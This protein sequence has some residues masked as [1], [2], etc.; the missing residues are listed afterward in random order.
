MLLKYA[1]KSD[2]ITK[3][4]N[5]WSNMKPKYKNIIKYKCKIKNVQNK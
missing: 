2:N 3:I 4:W 5:L 1:K